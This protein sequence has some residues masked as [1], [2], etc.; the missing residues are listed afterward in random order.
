MAFSIIFAL[1]LGGLL[2]YWIGAT[3]VGDNKV[4]ETHKMLR[5]YIQDLKRGI[6]NEDKESSTVTGET[7][8]GLNLPKSIGSSLLKKVG[9]DFDFKAVKGG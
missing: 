4:M 1:A 3:R 9:N 7:S 5:K 6:E 2:G 8:T